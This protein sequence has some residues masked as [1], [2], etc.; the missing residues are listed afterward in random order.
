MLKVMKILEANIYGYGHFVDSH[1]DISRDFQI[2]TGENESGKSTFKSFI[3]SILFGFPTKREKSEN[4]APKKGSIYGGN[5]LITQRGHKYVI[6][7]INSDKSSNLSI[8]DKQTGEKVPESLLKKWLSGIDKQLFNEIYAVNQSGLH[9]VLDLKP[10]ELE[11]NFYSIATSGSQEIFE[12]QKKFMKVAGELYKPNGRV[13]EI[14]VMLREYD[15]QQKQTQHLINKLDESKDLDKRISELQEQNATI[16]QEK[17]QYE[18]DFLELQQLSS[19]WDVYQDV[20]LTSRKVTDPVSK[21]TIETFERIQ[22]QHNKISALEENLSSIE[23]QIENIK[24]QL[25]EKDFMEL[26][27]YLQNKEDFDN[28]FDSL[29]SS[30]NLT[31]HEAVNSERLSRRNKN[32]RNNEVSLIFLGIF[33]L[34]LLMLIFV[35][36]VP[37]KISG[38]IGIIIGVYGFNKELKKDSSVESQPISEQNKFDFCR[39]KLKLTNDYSENLEKIFNFQRQFKEQQNFKNEFE[40]RETF[41]NQERTAKLSKLREEQIIFDTQLEEVEYDNFDSFRSMYFQ[42]QN[43]IEVESKL[44]GLKSQLSRNVI[45]NLK[46][47]SSKREIEEEKNLISNKINLKRIDSEDKTAQLISYKMQLEK[48][49]NSNEIAILQQEAANQRA[50]IN[51][52]IEDW[53]S[54]VLSTKWLDEYLSKLSKDRLPQIIELSTR[55]FEKLTRGH[56]ISIVLEKTQF[57]LLTKDNQEFKVNELSRATAEQLYLSLR[58]AFVVTFNKKIGLPIIID[59]GFVNFDRKRKIQIIDLLLEISSE[60]QIL[61]FTVDISVMCDKVSYEEILV[62]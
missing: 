54:L 56:F 38:I 26:N 6:E 46:R 10:D 15:E 19:S 17:K 16:L 50:R 60:T 62:I 47:F 48:I 31:R 45:N 40:T 5:L 20:L 43:Q 55:F 3:S 28:L 59:D 24:L 61:C 21:I 13:P 51:T 18:Q 41:L 8:M 7:R 27:F 37:F 23:K 42:Q 33:V 44:Q 58:L 9:A 53:L 29:N 11:K 39:E 32:L 14:N 52:K 36:N 25:K 2:I 35:S 49:G 57:L 12:T 22:F 1:F 34:S 30:K 4:Y